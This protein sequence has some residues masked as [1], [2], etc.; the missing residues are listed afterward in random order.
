MVI[1]SKA[2]YLFK[3]IPNKISTQFFVDVES[4]ISK[5]IWNNKKPRITKLFS[6]VK[7]LLGKS[8]SPTPTSRCTTEQL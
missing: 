2:I 5:F 7:E 4:A 1:L 8:H 3:A 6:T